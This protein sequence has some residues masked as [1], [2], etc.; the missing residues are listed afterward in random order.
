M[1]RTALTTGPAIIRAWTDGEPGPPFLVEIVMVGGR[2]YNVRGSHQR[3]S[4]KTGWHIGTPQATTRRRI[5]AVT[6]ELRA[7]AEKA[8]KLRKIQDLKKRRA[9]RSE[10]RSYY[11]DQL[12]QL[13]VQVLDPDAEIARLDSEIAQLE[14]T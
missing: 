14:A 11:A 3:Y 12:E 2:Q 13:R 7:E 8:A 5:E 6:H 1:K 10:W 4:V 9:A